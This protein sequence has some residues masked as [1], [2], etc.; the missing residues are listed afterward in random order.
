MN[1][2]ISRFRRTTDVQQTWKEYG[3]TPPSED[4]KIQAKWQFFRTLN[5]ETAQKENENVQ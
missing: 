1:E 5:T 3:W 4:P 2:Q